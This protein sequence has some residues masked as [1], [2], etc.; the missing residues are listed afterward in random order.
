M[1]SGAR[2]HVSAKSTKPGRE[3]RA[4]RRGLAVRAI[5]AAQR[6]G[7]ALHH[8]QPR[9][10]LLSA[11]KRCG[12]GV[13]RRCEFCD[14]GGSFAWATPLTLP[15]VRREIKSRKLGGAYWKTCGPIHLGRGTDE[16]VRPHTCV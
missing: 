6:C 14:L 5:A 13:A 7:R 4:L 2:M 8:L 9:W 10:K 3:R 11:G 12:T 15:P 1:S 16:C